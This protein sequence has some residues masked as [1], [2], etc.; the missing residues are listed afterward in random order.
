MIRYNIIVIICAYLSIELTFRKI[1]SNAKTARREKSE[2]RIGFD[3]SHI[4][5]KISFSFLHVSKTVA[6]KR[7]FKNSFNVDAS[8]ELDQKF[9]IIVK[10]RYFPPPV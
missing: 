1:R 8:I 10:S 4:C 5:K 7:T 3:L 9:K 6:M 2:N